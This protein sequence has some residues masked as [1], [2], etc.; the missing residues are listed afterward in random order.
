VGYHAFGGFGI[1]GWVWLLGL[2][3]AIRLRSRNAFVL[4][5]IAIGLYLFVEL[6]PMDIGLVSSQLRYALVYRQWRFASLLT[7]AWVPLG[8]G[9]L[10]ALW[11]RN[12]LVAAL[13]VAACVMIGYP[14][15]LRNYD[16]LRGSQADLRESA[17]FIV[18]R[19]GRVFTDSFAL[20]PLQY[21]LRSAEA[22]SRLR[23]ITTLGATNPAQGDLAIIGGRR[24]IELLADVWERDLPSWCRSAL[25]T[26]NLLPSGWRRLLRIRGRHDLTRTHDLLILEYVGL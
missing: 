13:I 24:S 15:L 9:V 5:T 2:A 8:G 7:P 14:D 1:Q 17:A 22:A 19:S 4:A 18:P 11:E 23:D 6:F 26:P 21:H 25:D 10:A 3:H 16:V 20:I 12:R